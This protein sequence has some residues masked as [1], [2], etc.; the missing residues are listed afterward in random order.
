[1][2]MIVWDSYAILLDL[3]ALV[4]LVASFV[5]LDALR[6]L[7]DIEDEYQNCQPKYQ[8]S[9]NKNSLLKCKILLRYFEVLVCGL[10]C[11]FRKDSQKV[12]KLTKSHAST[13][14]FPALLRGLLDV[15]H[16]F[17]VFHKSD[18]ASDT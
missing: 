12:S 17:S 16:K 10:V 11:L 6:I 5:I 9:S 1:M 8:P 7:Q 14:F 4:C 3:C 2:Y 18:G 13:E 15:F